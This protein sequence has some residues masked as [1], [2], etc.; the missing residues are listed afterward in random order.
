VEVTG[1][2]AVVRDRVRSA[3]HEGRCI[4]LVPTMGAFHEGHLALMRQARGAG[5][6]VVVS[7]FVNPTQFR[8]GEDLSTYPREP[9][10]DRALAESE[11]VD[12]LFVPAVEEIYPPGFQ[13]RVEVD[14]LSRPLC[15]A[16]RPGHFQGVAT[17]V[18][19]LFQIAQPDLAYFGEK[20]FQQL[21]LVERLVA[22]LNMPVEIVPVPI[23]R[24]A[25]GVAMSSRNRLLSPED[26]MAAQA[27]PRARAASL[28]TFRSGERNAATIRSAALEALEAEPRCR[29]DYVEVVDRETMAPIERCERPALLAIAAFFGQTRLIDNETLA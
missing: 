6:F 10:R 14:A 7:L 29:A 1:A 11:H 25:D 17:V 27:I 21:R 9:E 5:G 3:R 13:T 26:R 18:T 2:I 12:L 19:K 28:A 16:S 4:E 15:G 8:P 22:D 23:V 20:D 24:E